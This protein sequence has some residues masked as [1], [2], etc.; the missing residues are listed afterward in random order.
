MLKAGHVY[1]RKLSNSIF[2]DLCFTGVLS[3]GI[4]EPSDLCLLHME[5]C[6]QHN[7]ANQS[8]RKPRLG[9]WMP[10]GEDVDSCHIVDARSW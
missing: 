8:K 2:V 4:V 5:G 3:A 10:C 9:G 7:Q 1:G 6:A